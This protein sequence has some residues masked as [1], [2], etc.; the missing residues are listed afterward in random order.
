MSE[1]EGEPLEYYLW[2]PEWIKKYTIKQ[3]SFNHVSAV[4]EWVV[5][6]VDYEAKKNEQ[7]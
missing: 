4:S 1:K 5:V 2:L 6:T 7:D 3:M